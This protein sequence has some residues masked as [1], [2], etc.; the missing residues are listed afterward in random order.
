M[1]LKCTYSYWENESHFHGHLKQWGLLIKLCH[2]SNL[3]LRRQLVCFFFPLSKG[4]GPD[5]F[6]LL[7]PGKQRDNNCITNRP[8]FSFIENF[9]LL[10]KGYH[11]WPNGLLLYNSG[12][13]C[14]LLLSL[15]YLSSQTGIEHSPIAEV[16]EERNPN[17]WTAR[18][19]PG[20]QRFNQKYFR[21][22]NQVCLEILHIL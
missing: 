13:F 2:T 10:L 12:I 8:S 21:W 3:S 18:E 19:V 17:P 22:K 15:W 4:P 7:L 1:W 20:P 6:I 11:F 14:A 9:P 16:E 5:D